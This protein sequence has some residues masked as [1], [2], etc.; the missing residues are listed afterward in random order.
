MFTPTKRRVVSYAGSVLIK[1]D[2]IGGDDAGV[3]GRVASS[4]PYA[5]GC[6]MRNE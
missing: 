3:D 6:R 2:V 1:G 5:S 4:S